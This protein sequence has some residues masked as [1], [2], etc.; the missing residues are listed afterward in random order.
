M[1]ALVNPQATASLRPFVFAGHN[2]DTKS[3]QKHLRVI[4]VRL[5]AL[6]PNIEHVV[7]DTFDREMIFR[8]QRLGITIEEYPLF[9]DE[10]DVQLKS[11][12]RLL[13]PNMYMT[14]GNS[15]KEFQALSFVCNARNIPMITG[16]N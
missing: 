2:A 13:M 7:C 4:M 3:R 15:L 6:S 12:Q 11:M 1:Y 10:F 14:F 16:Y 8:L 5:I 9:Q